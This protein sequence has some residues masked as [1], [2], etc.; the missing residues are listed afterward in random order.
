MAPGGVMSPYMGGP[1][2]PYADNGNIYLAGDT[3]DLND[4]GDTDGYKY[5]TNEFDVPGGIDY[6]DLSD[7]ALNY[8]VPA[9]KMVSGLAEAASERKDGG[10]NVAGKALSRGLQGATIGAKLGSIVPGIGTLVG[11]GIGA[12]AGAVTG[13]V[14]AAKRNK[15]VAAAKKAEI[16]REKERRDSYSRGVLASFP[17]TGVKEAGYFM[18]YGGNMKMP[19]MYGGKKMM[20]NGGKTELN[21]DQEFVFQEWK[22]TLPENLQSDTEMYDLRG[23]WLSGEQPEYTSEINRFGNVSREAHLFSRN[24][25]TGQIL[26][27]PNHPTYDK[28]LNSE[29]RQ[30]YYPSMDVKTGTMYTQPYTK[31]LS[32]RPFATNQEYGYGGKSI[33]ANGGNPPDNNPPKLFREFYDSKR[34]YNEAVKAQQQGLKYDANPLADPIKGAYN[35]NT[36]AYSLGIAGH[37]LTAG[38]GG[39]PAT[40]PEVFFQDPIERNRQKQ[41]NKI[42]V[43]YRKEMPLNREIKYT[44]QFNRSGANV[45]PT[46]PE[47]ATGLY[48]K[49]NPLGFKQ[50]V[51]GMEGERYINI[52][53]GEEVPYQDKRYIRRMPLSGNT[54]IIRGEKEYGYGGKKMFNVG[55]M[56]M[57]QQMQ[58]QQPVSQMAMQEQGINPNAQQMPVQGGDTQEVANGVQQVVGP[59]HE[60]GG[61]DIGPN[62][63]VEG[64]E[65]LQNTQ[66][67]VNVFS[68]RLEVLPGVTFAEQAAK[69]GEQKGRYEKEHQTAN[70]IYSK[71][72][73]KRNIQKVDIEMKR[74]FDQQEA[75]KIEHM[76]IEQGIE[77]PEGQA[78]FGEALTGVLPYVDNVTNAIITAKTPEIPDPVYDEAVPLQTRYN[79]NPQMEEIN[80][81]Q[82]NLQKNLRSNVASSANLRG[83]MIAS[84]ALA[85]QARN[86][87]FGQKENVETQLKNQDALNRQQVNMGNVAKEN[88]YKTMKMHRIDDIH[89]R[90]SGNVANM[91]QDAQMQIAEE[92]LR[93]KDALTLEIVKQKYKESGVYNR[94]IDAL[95]KAYEKGDITYKQF[96]ERMGAININK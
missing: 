70:N 7:K 61:V 10:A 55:G 77:N 13:G 36:G 73:A 93:K 56:M 24:P 62:T 64:G 94:N 52:V 81:Q 78:A 53:D 58:Q 22:K 74:L 51:P 35:L 50:T 29:F 71:N 86:Q 68:D 31:P 19:Y 41:L 43:E 95:F 79:I 59:R 14:N 66:E 90:I 8:G 21:P 6:Q 91:A 57:Q 48:P 72:R 16:E 20:P 63:E 25:N 85:T 45:P 82:A 23:A 18:G 33:M 17:T 69:L 40:P 39:A 34:A 1:Y 60:Q 87:L 5:G 96:Q 30:G 46:A 47:K 84:G 4:D 75:M 42:P 65:V 11:G 9:A 92:N 49:T 28:T 67:G 80:R 89:Q 32:P 54:E 44:D 2:I 83:S 15:E 3:G 76:K 88:Q 37:L 12:I 27:S 38:T 26:K